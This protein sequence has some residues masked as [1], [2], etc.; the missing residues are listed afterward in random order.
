MRDSAKYNDI[1]IL[2]IRLVLGLFFVFLYGAPRLLGGPEQW[3][4]VGY[5]M[6]YFGIYFLP[7]VWG[8]I[9]VCSEFLGGILLVL[10]L[11]F[12]Q[13]SFFLFMTMFVA[14]ISELVNRGISGAAHPIELAFIMLSF[15][16]TGPG[17]YSLEYKFQRRRR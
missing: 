5:G 11:Y 3:R 15:M 2:I 6:H 12:R 7:G 10:G 13:A 8:F 9:A 4:L 1:G 17:K 16:F 14:S